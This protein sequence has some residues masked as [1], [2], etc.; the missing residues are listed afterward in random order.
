VPE[1][2]AAAFQRFRNGRSSSRIVFHMSIDVY[3]DFG[4]G[5]G[6]ANNDSASM[7]KAVISKLSNTCEN[8]LSQKVNTDISIVASD[9]SVFECHKCFLSG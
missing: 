4:G 6:G 5:V 9:D 8:I 3:L 1:Q 2:V 7:D